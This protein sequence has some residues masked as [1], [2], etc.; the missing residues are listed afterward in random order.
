M[1]QDIPLHLSQAHSQW[2]WCLYIS[3]AGLGLGL[4]SLSAPTPDF[5]DEPVLIAA[6]I[7]SVGSFRID[8]LES[9]AVDQ[10]T[11]SLLWFLTT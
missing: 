5:E 2:T 9:G 10:L 1:K 8:D 4:D 11:C 3:V 6:N 7:D